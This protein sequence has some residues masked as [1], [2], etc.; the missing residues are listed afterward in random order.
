MDTNEE[1]IR[2][3]TEWVLTMQPPL[4]LSPI[5]HIPCI[6][7]EGV[8]HTSNTRFPHFHTRLRKFLYKASC[9]LMSDYLHI[10]ASC[11]QGSGYLHL[12]ASCTQGSEYL[13]YLNKVSCTWRSNYLLYLHKA[14]SAWGEITYRSTFFAGFYCM[15]LRIRL[16]SLPIGGFL[17]LK[18]RLPTG[19]HF[20]QGFTAPEDQITFSSNR[21]LP[22]SEDHMTYSSYTM[23]SA[24]LDQ[25]IYSSYTKLLH[26]GIRIPPPPIRGFLYLRIR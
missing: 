7:K 11:T 14:F 6:R 15:H 12:K 5:F 26:L 16:P 8:F 13:H 23:L 17:Q 24:T 3:L 21:R 18:I 1:D 19:V 10:K 9:P 2:F 4:S 20:L 25:V 22:A